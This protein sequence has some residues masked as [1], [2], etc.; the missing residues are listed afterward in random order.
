MSFT[1]DIKEELSIVKNT[2]EESLAELSGF[3]RNGSKVSNHKIDLRTENIYVAKRLYSLFKESFNVEPLGVTE[4][5]LVFKTNNL[6]RIEIKDKVEE[7]LL[8]LNI[9]DDEHKIKARVDDYLVD[10]DETKAAYIRG[11]FLVSANLSDPKNSSYHLEFICPLKF[12]AVFLQRLLNHFKLNSRIGR[13]NKKYLVYIK[14]AEKISDFLK[15]I[16]APKA[17]LYFENVRVYKEQKNLT[18]RLNN[19][20]Q[21]NTEK[22]ML[23]AMN[24]INNIELIEQVTGL[25]SYDDNI[26]RTIE[27]RLKYPES[28]LRELSE[29]MTKDGYPISKS[30]LNHRFRKLDEDA[31]YLRRKLRRLDKEKEL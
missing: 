3:I 17:V 25:S 27:Y 22:A 18:N 28:S 5:N 11:A 29:I 8:T 16:E 31:R 6:Y 7:I 24:D 14:E 26:K 30:G 4:L 9:I 20:E 12:E 13:K 10:D 1:S 2:K 19:T 15:L 21:A 23:S